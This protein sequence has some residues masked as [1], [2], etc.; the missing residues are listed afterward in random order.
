MLPRHH[1]RVLGGLLLVLAWSGAASAGDDTSR[2]SSPLIDAPQ[3]FHR[4]SD[5]DGPVAGVW[6]ALTG[7]EPEPAQPP[8]PPPGKKAKPKPIT[9]RE[10]LNQQPAPSVNAELAAPDAG[11]PTEHKTPPAGKWL[12][13]GF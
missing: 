2:L 12:E 8:P 5:T 4:A 11:P 1:A 10:Y 13:L 9:L 7:T 6:S 3:R